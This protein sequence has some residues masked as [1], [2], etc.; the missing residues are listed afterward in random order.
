[1]S[2]WLWLIVA[3]VFTLVEVTNLALYALFVAAGALAA[4]V[5]SAAGGDLALQLVAFGVVTIGG[6]TIARRPLL[7]AVEGRRHHRPLVSGAHGLIGQVGTVVEQ[8]HGPHHPGLVRARGE[9]W[10]A[11]SYDDEP[12]E[13]GEVVLIVD[14]ERTRLVVTSN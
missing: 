7:A 13:P 1:M 10:P 2:A 3:A 6:V 9:D 8:V 5:T 4:A 14:L 11:L 12:H